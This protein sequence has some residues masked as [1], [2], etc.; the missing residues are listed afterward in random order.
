M[1]GI[2]RETY[3]GCISKYILPLKKE[4]LDTFQVPVTEIKI[5]PI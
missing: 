2:I 4:L 1:D 3:D 5:K